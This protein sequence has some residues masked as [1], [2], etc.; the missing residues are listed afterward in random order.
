M[1]FQNS[2]V[3]HT[4]SKKMVNCVTVCFTLKYNVWCYVLCILIYSAEEVPL[5]YNLHLA[6]SSVN[7]DRSKDRLY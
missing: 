6:I 5:V 3:H 2:Y 4:T 1:F 7:V